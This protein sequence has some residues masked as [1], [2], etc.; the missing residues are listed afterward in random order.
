M[1]RMKTTIASTLMSAG[2]TLAALSG[3]ALAQSATYLR[4][5]ASHCEIF[6]SL[7]RFVPSTCAQPG[8]VGTELRT[9]GIKTRGL[10]TRGIRFH[11]ETDAAPTPAGFDSTAPQEPQPEVA[12]V[13]QANP[14]DELAF[15]MRVQFE[16]DSFRL[17]D[18]AKQVLDRVAAVLNDDLMT[19]KQILIEGHADA[20]GPDQY[21]L[22]LSQMRARSVRAYLI[23]QHGVA[24]ERL[25]FEG[26]GEFEPYNRNDPYDGINRRVEFHNVTG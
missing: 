9:R 2:L 21:N 13:E 10:K 5:D 17:T 25:P 19:D 26:K 1:T 23:R 7:S 16:Y 20:H 12:A 3:P 14:P 8:D 6:R 22:S 24:G 18:Q 4:D 15:A 11:G